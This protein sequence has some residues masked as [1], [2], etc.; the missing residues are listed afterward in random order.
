[1]KTQKLS[2]DENNQNNSASPNRTYTRRQFMVTGSSTVAALSIIPGQ[3]LGKTESLSRHNIPVIVNADDNTYNDEPLSPSAKVYVVDQNH[4]EANDKGAGT[5]SKP[6]KTISR[7]MTNLVPGDTVIIRSGIYRETPVLTIS[8]AEGKPIVIRAEQGANVIIR[9]SD[10]VTSWNREAPGVYSTPFT[11]KSPVSEA[12]LK[13]LGFAVY[14]EQVFVNDSLLKLVPSVADLEKNTFYVD[15]NNQKIIIR[16]PIEKTPE[17]SVIE[18]STRMNWFDIRADYIVVSGLKMERSYATVQ[19]GGFL[20]RGNDWL[21]ENN[22]FSLSGGGKGAS[23]SGNNGIVRNNNIHHNGQMGFSLVGRKILFEQNRVYNNNTN[24]YQ[25]W[26]QGGCKIAHAYECIIRRNSFTDEV[27]GPG[28]WLDID[29]YNNSIE[30][31]FF[32]NCGH[33]AI[34]IEISYNNLIRNNIILNSCY[35]AWCGSGILIQLS[36]KTRIYNNLIINSEQCGIHLRWHNRNRTTGSEPFRPSDPEEFFKVHG[37]RPDDWMGPTDQY[38]ESEND[39]RNN[40][41]I[42]VE[43]ASVAIIPTLHPKYFKNNQSDYNFFGHTGNQHP[44]EGTQRLIEWQAYTGFDMHSMMP[45][46]AP[47]SLKLEDLFVD[48]ANN[49]FRLKPASPLIG[50]GTPLKEV[51]DDFSGNPRPADRPMD[52]GPYA[53]NGT[54]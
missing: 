48:P 12:R 18:V 22:D 16:L 37:F 46:T 30:Q 31:N 1:M 38:P 36:C 17:N 7:A 29:N 23:F 4:P 14:G 44:M 27:Y 8:G 25:P 2:R 15:R 51:T 11:L 42:N 3:V 21:I 49:D 47:G 6:F 45:S 35:H 19:K 24:K 53:Y 10:L 50:K 5:Y 13:Q 28:L 41:I 40:V 54:K 34:M 39:I 52:I 20:I 9:G 32:D 43:N 26:E 33:A